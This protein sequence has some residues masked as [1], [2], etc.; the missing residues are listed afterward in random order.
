MI[1]FLLK[2]VVHTVL[3][4]TRSQQ[5]TINNTRTH[6][7]RFLAF[8]MGTAEKSAAWLRL[9]VLYT[10]AHA[11]AHAHAHA[12]SWINGTPTNV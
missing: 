10:H 8:W 4:P 12:Q 3:P 9:L 11:Y 2:V 6:A 5:Q 1:I 7:R